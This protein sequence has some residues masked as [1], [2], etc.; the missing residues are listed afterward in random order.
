MS[1]VMQQCVLQTVIDDPVFLNLLITFFAIIFIWTIAFLFVKP[2]QVSFWAGLFV[3]SSFLTFLFVFHKLRADA[4]I[5]VVPEY[6]FLEIN[7]CYLPASPQNPD[8][9]SPLMDPLNGC[10]SNL[11]L[12]IVLD[13]NFVRIRLHETETL[14]DALSAIQRKVRLIQTFLLVVHGIDILVT[15]LFCYCFS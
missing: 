4:V 13:R 10:D 3:I 14:R 7:T 2:K 15:I 6:S 11:V 9:W 8:I 12:Q 5:C 1:K